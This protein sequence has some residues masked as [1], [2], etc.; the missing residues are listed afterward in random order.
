M[1]ILQLNPPAGG[2]LTV[3]N[4]LVNAAGAPIAPI[5]TIQNP[6]PR[7]LYPDKPIFN[8]VTVP[9]DRKRRNAYVQ[10]YNA[11]IAHQITNNDLFEVG[12]VASKSTNVD[13]STTSGAI[14]KIRWSAAAGAVSSFCSH[15]PTSAN[16]CSPTG[17]RPPLQGVGHE[18]GVRVVGVEDDQGIENA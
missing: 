16:S 15:L 9:P 4:E 5:A 3:R 8:V 10:N 12:W 1:N 17:R 14:L 2:S 11:T 18:L 6:V 13:T 7:E